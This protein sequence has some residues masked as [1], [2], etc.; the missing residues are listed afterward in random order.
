MTTS[1]LGIGVIGS[2]LWGANHAQA[3]SI[4]P[5]TRLVAVCD[6]DEA[7]ARELAA[8]HGAPSVYA[9]YRKLLE[10]PAV[11]AISIATPDFSHTAIILDALAAGKHVLSEKPLATS[12]AEA[13]QVGDAVAGSDR[14][15][16]VD[17]ANRAS[18]VFAAARED[19]AAG[20]IGKVVHANGRLSN[21]TWVPLE[22]LSWSARSSALWFLGS[23]LVD[24]LRFLFDDDIVRVFALSRKGVLQ[25]RGV[26][27]ADVHLSM[28]E[29]SKG[30]IATIE[31]SW[32]L[33]PSN[34]QVFDLNVRIVG[35]AG[36]L[37]LNPS[38]NNAYVQLAD[39][40]M[41]YKDLL[42]ATPVGGGRI[43][44]F[45]FEAIARFVD[46][47]TTGVPVLASVEDG[48]KATRV[49]S[50]IEQSAATGKPVDVSS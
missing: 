36:Q 35:D 15:V 31:N 20:R 19:I 30:T 11:D 12:L 45:V 42:G 24:M 26:D 3:F 17:F 6:I 40:G 34:P 4:L 32:I 16:M 41:K 25:A 2:G 43:G 18:P 27:T 28:L 49:L 44:G 22:M 8:A 7:R 14:V 13:Q 29:F 48:L 37:D 46:S 33:S 39:N 38:H 23:H 5:N 21:T 9:D 47:V 50:A 1:E 10:N